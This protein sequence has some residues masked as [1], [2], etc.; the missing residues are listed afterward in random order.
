MAPGA[1][2]TYEVTVSNAGPATATD[3]VVHET[4]DPF[5]TYVSDTV[6][7]GCPVTDPGD[8]VTTGASLDCPLGDIAAAGSSS[9]GTS[10]SSGCASSSRCRLLLLP[11][12]HTC[13]ACRQALW[14]HR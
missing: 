7:G 12:S 13:W 5:M 1:N 6:A 3:V 8:G 9:S 14:S 2:V 11:C 10:A 4:L